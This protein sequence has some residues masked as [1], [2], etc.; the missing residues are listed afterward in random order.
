MVDAA[1]VAKEDLLTNRLEFP[2]RTG[3]VYACKHNPGGPCSI[4]VKL[5]R[6]QTGAMLRLPGPHHDPTQLGMCMQ[7]IKAG[8]F[9]MHFASKLLL[10]GNCMLICVCQAHQSTDWTASPDVSVDSCC[11]SCC[12]GAFMC[13]D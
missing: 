12:N 4:P 7:A 11:C 10:Q 8:K 5:M 3:Q 2:G 13:Q 9:V 1:T 6:V